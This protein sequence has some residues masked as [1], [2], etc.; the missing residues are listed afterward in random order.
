MTEKKKAPFEQVLERYDL[1]EANIQKGLTAYGVGDESEEP[2]KPNGVE[3]F[4]KMKGKIP[5]L[6]D[7][8]TASD[9]Q[10]GTLHSYFT[11]WSVY[12]HVLEDKVTRLYETRKKKVAALVVELK[13]FLKTE[14][15]VKATDL[16]VEVETYRLHEDDLPLYVQADA[17][18]L[19]AKL[20][21]TTIENRYKDYKAIAHAV[22][23]EMSRRA[24]DF[25]SQGRSYTVSNSSSPSG[26]DSRW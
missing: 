18:L 3:N 6:G 8:T 5:S 23:R 17:Q 19:E 26:G 2:G 1:V 24:S 9:V 22:S 15:K 7:L 12:L 21:K 11:D 20:L 13:K 10:V 14:K 25:K 4:I 16:M